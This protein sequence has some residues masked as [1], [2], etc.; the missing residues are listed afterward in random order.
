[1]EI[2]RNLARRKLRSTL[3][4]LGIVIGIFALT[5]MGAMAEHFNALLDGGVKYYGSS[6]MV[7]APDGQA[8]ILPMSKVDEIRRV[9]GVTAVVPNYEFL[10]RP[11]N[12]SAVN[13]GPPDEIVSRD[14][15][16]NDYNAL[17]TTRR[18]WRW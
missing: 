10:A 3:T 6:I 11:G 8:A 9:P 5:A 7:G 14:P 13:F 1:M 17:R 2:V 16:Q 4:I 18:C 12:L 15:V